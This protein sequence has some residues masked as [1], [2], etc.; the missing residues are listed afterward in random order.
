MSQA[1]CKVEI[2]SGNLAATV[3]AVNRRTQKKK[4]E[5]SEEQLNAMAGVMDRANKDI[6]K[7]AFDQ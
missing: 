5:F 1:A 4:N 2:C 6:Q 7:I 3:E